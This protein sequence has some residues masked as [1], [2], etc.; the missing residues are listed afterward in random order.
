MLDP[1]TLRDNL[2]RTVAA[3]V[4]MFHPTAT[5]RVQAFALLGAMARRNY[6]AR[7]EERAFLFAALPAS[8]L[9]S[10]GAPL[11]EIAA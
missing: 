6:R 3:T 8:W 10:E 11:V 7:P 4:A 5:R 2:D 9:R 1:R